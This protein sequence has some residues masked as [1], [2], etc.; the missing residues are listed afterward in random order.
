MTSVEDTPRDTTKTLETRTRL[1]GFV[2]SLYNTLTFSFM[3]PLLKKGFAN[4]LDEYSATTV[5]P[6]TEA[7]GD[8]QTEFFRIYTRFRKVRNRSML[9]KDPHMRTDVGLSEIK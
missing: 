5:N 1:R 8:L 4:E 6:L 9:A 7:I 2:L 3:N